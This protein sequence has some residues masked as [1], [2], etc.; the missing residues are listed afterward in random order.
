M[1]TALDLI[2]IVVES[3]EMEDEEHALASKEYVWEV[4]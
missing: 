3:H 1:R 4:R 2:Y